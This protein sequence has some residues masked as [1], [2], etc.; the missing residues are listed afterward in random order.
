MKKVGIIY[1][2]INSA[3]NFL[4]KLNFEEINNWWSQK[5]LQKIKDEF[6]HNYANTENFNYKNLKKLF[7]SL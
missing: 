4:N 6:V 3:K 7:L 2:D 5:E 1:T